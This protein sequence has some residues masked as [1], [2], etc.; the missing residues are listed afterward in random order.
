M[1]YILSLANGTLAIIIAIVA[2]QYVLAMACLY[3]LFKYKPRVFGLV[4]WNFIIVV[5]IFIGPALYLI[6][7]IKCKEPGIFVTKLAVKTDATDTPPDLTQNENGQ[8]VSESQEVPNK[9]DNSDNGEMQ[10]NI[11]DKY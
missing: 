11:N 8:P 5:V 9:N 3:R 10:N 4:A 1:Y 6:T 2:V 7:N